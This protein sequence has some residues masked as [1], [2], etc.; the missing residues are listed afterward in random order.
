MAESVLH[1][2]IQPYLLYLQ[3]AFYLIQSFL[4]NNADNKNTAAKVKIEIPS[5]TEAMGNTDE[6]NR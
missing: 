4:G 2:R 6:T 5:Q 3:E 1:L